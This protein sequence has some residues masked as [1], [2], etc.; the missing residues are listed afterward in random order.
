MERYPVVRIRP[1]QNGLKHHKVLPGDEP[2]LVRVRNPEEGSELRAANLGEV[3][4]GSDGVHELLA[5]EVSA[6]KAR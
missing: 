6:G 5:V 3:A 2:A 4:L 1:L